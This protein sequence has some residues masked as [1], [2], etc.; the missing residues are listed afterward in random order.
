MQRCCCSS[1]VA[2]FFY[3][4]PIAERKERK[5]EGPRAREKEEANH[6][7]RA[8]TA[9]VVFSASGWARALSLPCPFSFLRL[10]ATVLHAQIAASRMK[11]RDCSGSRQHR[12]Q[13]RERHQSIAR[14]GCSIAG[15]K[16]IA[17]ASAL[18]SPPPFAVFS[19]S[20]AEL[21]SICSLTPG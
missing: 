6:R 10:H 3:L 4:S 16:K 1:P 9:A 20:P 14:G 5:R 8:A 21:S 19:C 12:G 18:S 11:E 7:R 15:G 17:F 13:R 2:A